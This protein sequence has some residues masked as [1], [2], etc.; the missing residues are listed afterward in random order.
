MGRTEVK[1][2]GKHLRLPQ[3]EKFQSGIKGESLGYGNFKW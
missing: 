2:E 3:F 1:T